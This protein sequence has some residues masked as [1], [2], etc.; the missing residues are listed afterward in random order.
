MTTM[1]EFE[2]FF[3]A[4]RG[5]GISHSRNFAESGRP[6]ASLVDQ[7]L[8]GPPIGRRNQGLSKAAQA[9]LREAQERA[10]RQQARSRDFLGWVRLGRMAG[11]P[12]SA[13]KRHTSAR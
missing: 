11:L 6:E 10:A 9:M 5:R 8:G 7:I 4:I 3:D 13:V 2:D 1:A 12:Y